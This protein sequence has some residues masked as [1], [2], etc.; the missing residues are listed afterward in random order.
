MEK[1][2][3]YIP[4]NTKVEERLILTENDVIIG[5]H[6]K[7]D[8]GIKTKGEIRAGERVKILGD[9]EADGDVSIGLW[10]LVDGDLETKNDAF[11]GERS[12]INGELLV[13]GDLEIGNDVEIKETFEANGYITI[14]NPIPLYIYFFLLLSELIRRKE[15]EEIEEMLDDLFEEDEVSEKKLVIPKKVEFDSEIKSPGDIILGENCR[16]IGNLRGEKVVIEKETT[17]FGG[18]KSKDNVKIKED[19]IVHGDIRS[20]KE[21]YL[22]KNTN[23]LGNIIAEKVK[24]HK[25]AHVN[26]KIKA[27][28]VEIFPKEDI[29]EEEEEVKP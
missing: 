15:T 7:I 23:V 19:T 26:E 16:F 17:L 9:V 4:K 8:Y 21:V 6:S 5:S 14:K 24:I 22:E 11:V 13:H 28:E 20:S 1:E 25:D 3:L 12:K 27:K 2:D 10:G 18:I 29:E